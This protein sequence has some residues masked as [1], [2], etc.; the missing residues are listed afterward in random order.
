MIALIFGLGVRTEKKSS[1]EAMRK[2]RKKYRGYAE[3]P[4]GSYVPG[5]PP[6]EGHTG[7]GHSGGGHSH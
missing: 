7:D 6:Y 3:E 5:P 4:G 1:K 2:M